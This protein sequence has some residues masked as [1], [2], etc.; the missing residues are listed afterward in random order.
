VAGDVVKLDEIVLNEQSYVM[1]ME[2]QDLKRER[3]LTEAGL[4]G[5]TLSEI[6]ADQAEGDYVDA[7]CQIYSELSDIIFKLKKVNAL[8]QRLTKERL[9][10]IY[11]MKE[12]LSQI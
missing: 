8:N 6:I 2:S 10:V 9:N 4:I 11:K 1:K 5:M 7:F 3:I 12:P